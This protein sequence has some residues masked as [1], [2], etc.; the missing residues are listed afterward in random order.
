MKVLSNSKRRFISDLGFKPYR[1]PYE[2]TNRGDGNENLVWND[3]L[4]MH[5]YPLWVRMYARVEG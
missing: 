2:L 4:Q 1:I 3:S 5:M